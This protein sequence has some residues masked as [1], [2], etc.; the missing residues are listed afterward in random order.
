MEG[1]GHVIDALNEF[2][3]DAET[4]LDGLLPQYIDQT[5]YSALLMSA[6][7]EHAARQK[8]MKS[9]TDNAEKLIKN[10]TRLS[11]AARQSEIT[12]Q[13]SE[14]VGGAD[15]LASQGDED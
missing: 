3:P 14:I 10:Y 13:I 6:A 12:Q 15:A 8:A 7:S 2:E 11:N 1:V 9:A 4:V 5:V